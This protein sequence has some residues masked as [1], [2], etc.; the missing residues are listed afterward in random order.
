MK[1]LKIAYYTEVDL[2][3]NDGPAVNEMEFLNEVSSF[4]DNKFIFVTIKKN[5]KFSNAKHTLFVPDF[6]LKL[7]LFHFFKNLII[8]ISLDN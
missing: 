1:S 5:N 3:L 8:F 4:S 2:S 7:I 6:K